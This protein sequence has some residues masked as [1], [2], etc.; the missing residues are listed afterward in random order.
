VAE[1]RKIRGGDRKLGWGNNLGLQRWGRVQVEVN[2]KLDT[3]KRRTS[4]SI[5]REEETG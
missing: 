1:K 2:T 4:A 5:G 3:E